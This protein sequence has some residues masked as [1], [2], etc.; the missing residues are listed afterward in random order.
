MRNNRGRYV[1]CVKAG[2]AEDLE[3]RKLYQ[4]LPDEAA[5]AHGHLRVVDESGE[6][7]LYPTEWFIAVDLSE[8]SERA[9]VAASSP[10]STRAR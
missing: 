7:Y 5:L 6:D 8:E 3:I 9:L 1:I 4:V 10:G 2:G